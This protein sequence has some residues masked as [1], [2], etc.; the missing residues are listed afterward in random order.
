MKRVS[1]V[2]AL[3]VAA[4]VQ[5]KAQEV[6]VVGDLSTPIVKPLKLSGPRI[7]GSYIPQIGNLNLGETFGDSAFVPDPF[8]TLFGWQFEWRYFETSNGSQGLFEVIP[9]IGGLDQGMIIPSLNLLVGYRNAS[10]FEFGAGPNINLVNPGFTVAIG[11]NLSTGHMNFPV[12]VGLTRGKEGWRFSLLM[13]F[14]KRDAR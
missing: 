2:L 4:L 3:M 14:N 7:G 6:P 13:G 10:G 5:V 11:Q 1:I 12:N 8:I 9:L